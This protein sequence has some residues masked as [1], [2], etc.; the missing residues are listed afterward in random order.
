MWS[1]VAVS[2][3]S[4]TT[5]GRA[6]AIRKSAAFVVTC[7]RQPSCLTHA[8]V[9][10]DCKSLFIS[11]VAGPPL[12]CRI[13][14]KAFVMSDMSGL[15]GRGPHL[16]AHKCRFQISSAKLVAEGNIPSPV[17]PARAFLT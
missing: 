15:Q 11:T 2:I 16:T 17:V 3:V 13:V 8:V 9:T 4:L 7:H 5:L 10:L 12:R 6:A 14:L 1:S